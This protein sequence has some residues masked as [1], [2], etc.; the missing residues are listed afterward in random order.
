MQR[1]TRSQPLACAAFVTLVFTL[2]LLGWARI[3]PNSISTLEITRWKLFGLDATRVLI[4]VVLLAMLGWWHTAGF[5]QQPTWSRLAPFLPL[6]LIPL[7]PLLFGSGFTVSDPGDIAVLVVTYLAVGFGEEAIFRGVVLRALESRGWMRAA[8]LSG[9][10]FG[11]MHLVN[12]ATSHNP[13]D[14]GFQVVYTA[15]MGFA[16][17]AAALVTDPS[18]H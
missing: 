13:G 2:G 17:S 5:T 7:V 15:L 18:G 9:L 10:L 12:L 4:P 14:V 16:Y 3:I 6:L 11:L 1:F 8:A